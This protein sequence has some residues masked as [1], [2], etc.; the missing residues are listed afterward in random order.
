ME[1]RKVVVEH[2]GELELGRDCLLHEWFTALEA[3]MFADEWE[4]R[5]REA[6]VRLQHGGIMVPYASGT[7]PV[8]RE[9]EIGG[10]P[11]L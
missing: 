11:Y 2:D 3:G 5:A 7:A 8:P 4:R 9:D 6:W 1:L 10:L